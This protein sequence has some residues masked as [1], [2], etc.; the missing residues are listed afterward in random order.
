MGLVYL[1]YKVICR[2]FRAVHM[3]DH[4]DYKYRPRRKPKPLVKKD[5]SKFS[6]PIPFF[7]GHFDPQA[8]AAFMARSFLQVI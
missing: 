6:F 3:K 4:P 7:H 8:A 5:L 2:F 1:L